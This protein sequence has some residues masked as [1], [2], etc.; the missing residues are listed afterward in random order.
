[1]LETLE[2]DRCVSHF[3]VL[4]RRGPAQGLKTCATYCGP[5]KLADFV[6][7]LSREDS[8]MEISTCT[9]TD[10]DMAT[11]WDTGLAF[12]LIIL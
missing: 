4:V 11:L 7:S 9:G 1:M 3:N 12:S 6:R 8:A 10:K 2:E 5:I